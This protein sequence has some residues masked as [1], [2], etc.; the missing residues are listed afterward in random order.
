LSSE[1]SVKLADFLNY[2]TQNTPWINLFYTRPALD[3]L[4]LNSLREAATPG[5]LK[6]N[7]ARRKTTYG[8]ES[9]GMAKKLGLPE[10][11]RVFN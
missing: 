9:T 11:L 1:E 2:G 5:Y 8:Q 10:Y 4:V 6:R 3:Y 7:E